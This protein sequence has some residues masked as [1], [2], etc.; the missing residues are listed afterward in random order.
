MAVKKIFKKENKK[1]KVLSV[2]FKICK[3]KNDFIVERLSKILG[4]KP[5]LRL[6]KQAVAG[7]TLSVAVPVIAE[8]LR[9][10]YTSP[11]ASRHGKPLR[12]G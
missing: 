7:Y 3:N 4:Q 2:I 11:G 12:P 8:L 9:V 10:E 5:S 6:S 1:E